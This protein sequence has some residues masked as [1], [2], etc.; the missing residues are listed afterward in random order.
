MFNFLQTIAEHG[1]RPAIKSL[2]GANSFGVTFSE[3]LRSMR[4]CAFSIN[5]T[6]GDISGKHIGIMCE[7]NYDYVV[8]LST[9]MFLRAV[10][11]PINIKE[12]VDN[13]DY[14]IK[15]SNIEVIIYDDK[16]SEKITSDVKKYQKET[17]L[18]EENEEYELKDFTDDEAEN[19]ILIIYTSGTTSRSKGVVLSV[20]NQFGRKKSVINSDFLGGPEALIGFKVYVGFPFYHVAGITA[21]YAALE[22]CAELYL[23]ENPD[24]ILFDLENETIDAG[25]VT[26]AVMNL[27]KK[28]IKR[29]NLSRLGGMKLIGTAGANVDLET[30]QLFLSN[31]IL[32]F[33]FYGMTETG[34][35]VTCNFD[36]GNHLESVGRPIP[37]VE[38][39]IQDGE[40]CIGGSQI[41][42]GYYKDPE[43]TEKCLYDGVIHTGDLGYIDEDGYVYITGRKKNLIILS[44]GENVSPEELESMI[45]KCNAVIEC[46]VYEKNDRIAASIFA[47]ENEQ[48]NIRGYVAELNK[49]LPIY[50]RIYKV[51]FT[52]NELEKTASGKIL[53]Q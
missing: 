50:K 23:S 34:G 24:N 20:D 19:P 45:Y 4:R 41:M 32:F 43:E 14:I 29:D 13:I 52:D 10:V 53:R 11:V 7:S 37:G 46:K 26:P 49:K 31:H 27:W 44:G 38:L 15:A 12:S 8:L 28:A 35:N 51:E 25:V 48:D 9:L 47:S 18:A 1:D 33:Q 22:C 17:F 40:I 36:V 42:Q 30:L 6:L 3:Y 2:N 39:T 5:K 16:L 21:L